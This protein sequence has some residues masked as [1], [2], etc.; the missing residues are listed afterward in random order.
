ME[1]HFCG[2]IR[3]PCLPR[4]KCTSSD[5][6]LLTPVTSLLG[7]HPLL[8]ELHGLGGDT[9]PILMHHQPYD[10]RTHEFSVKT[11][12]IRRAREPDS[13]QEYP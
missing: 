7:S 9:E 1:L 13:G 12:A 5:N 4:I 3:L 2:S 11:H 6:L 8:A 10:S